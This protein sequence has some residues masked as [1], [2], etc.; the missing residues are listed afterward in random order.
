MLCYGDRADRSVAGGI[1]YGVSL[2]SSLLKTRVAEAL[3]QADPDSGSTTIRIPAI[4]TGWRP[5]QHVRIRIP[6][7]QFPYNLEAHPFSIASSPEADGLKLVVKAIPTGWSSHLLKHAANGMGVQGSRT[8]RIVL[9]GPYGGFGNT[10]PES[11]SSV[12]LIAGGSGISHA[13]GVASSLV[14]RASSGTVRART[15]DLVWI[16]RNEP[17]GRQISMEL[18]ELVRRAKATEE[19]VIEGRRKGRDLPPP[20]A[21]RVEVYLSRTPI[22]DALPSK[23]SEA[24]NEEPEDPF[25]DANPFSDHSEA[26]KE[27]RAYLSR[28]NSTSSRVPAVMSKIDV[29]PRKPHFDLVLGSVVGETATRCLT[30]KRQANGCL[31][32]AC[33]PKSMV[34]SVRS[35]VVGLKWWEHEGVN[36][37]DYHEE[38]FGF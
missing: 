7:L 27:K 21:F 12:V 37:V 1:I 10:L 15:I 25:G 34:D 38:A 9:E 18:A 28:S 20:V 17:E 11:F 23:L 8:S 16:I 36:G 32:V 5:G 13:L 3:F 31:V 26:E 22:A 19:M 4:R 14:T 24:L 35:A 6:A 2:L 29:R 33:G 30:E